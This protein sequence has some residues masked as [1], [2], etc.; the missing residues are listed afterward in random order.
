MEYKLQAVRQRNLHTCILG[1]A[2]Y[3]LETGTNKFKLTI[4]AEGEILGREFSS[5]K[6]LS[7]RIEAY[8]IPTGTKIT[9]PT[10]NIKSRK[11]SAP[12]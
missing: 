12:A 6:P 7:T 9:C 11:N 8:S 1:F 4:G 3:T 5:I 10:A 2:S